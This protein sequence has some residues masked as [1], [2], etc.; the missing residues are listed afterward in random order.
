MGTRTAAA[1]VTTHKDGG[2][3]AMRN[4]N[5]YLAETPGEAEMNK[6]TGHG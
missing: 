2:G 4:R 3:A 1:H 5:E 6:G